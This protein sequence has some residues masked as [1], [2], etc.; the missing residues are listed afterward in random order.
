[1]ILISSLHAYA[2][3]VTRVINIQFLF[4]ISVHVRQLVRI[5]KK[6]VNLA[7]SQA[8]CFHNIL[9]RARE[10]AIVNYVEGVGTVSK[11]LPPPKT[12]KCV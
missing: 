3:N 9:A 7:C 10:Q 5:L 1:M 4:K 12:L 2:Y 6:T 11:I 8:N